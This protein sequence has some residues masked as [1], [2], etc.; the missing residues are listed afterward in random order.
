MKNSLFK[1]IGGGYS[2]CYMFYSRFNL[3]FLVN[4]MFL[5]C[6]ER[7]DDHGQKIIKNKL[8]LLKL[9]EMIGN[10]A[11]ANQVMGYSGDRPPSRYRKS[12]D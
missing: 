1:V 2:R 7:S 5:K 12:P 3:T 10:V 6:E 8:G 4:L 9:A 11:Q